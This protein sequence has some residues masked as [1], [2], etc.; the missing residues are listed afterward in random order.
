MSTL[1]LDSF[2][3]SLLE[4]MNYFH[5]F[6]EKHQLNYFLVG[7]TLL[8][9]VRH[10]GF[11]PWDDDLD[12]I[13]PRAD[14]ERFLK[15]HK[16]IKQPFKLQDYSTNTRYPMPFAK[17]TN[18]K[19]IIQNDTYIPFKSGV[20]LDIFPIDYT[21]ENQ[22]AQSLHYSLTKCLRILL[23]VKTGGFNKKKK[24]SLKF[25]TVRFTH[26]ITQFIPRKF[27][28]SALSVA[29]SFPGKILK[30][31]HNY[32]NLYGAWGAKESAPMSIF[33]HKKLYNFEGHKFWSVENADFW[34]N[35]VY[36]DYM[37]LP[38]LEKQVPTHF[39]LII[40]NDYE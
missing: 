2:K 7:G 23:V 20:W 9:A 10:Q 13:M 35:K 38:P 1:N 17:L 26:N 16:E 33:K 39:D 29:E 6:C 5:S 21:F 25:Q 14:Y 22:K 12:V 4:T 37:K 34:L 11:I 28:N 27:I 3:Y 32:I 18:T 31:K 24:S 15:L 36:G 19:L 8:G 40:K 30:R